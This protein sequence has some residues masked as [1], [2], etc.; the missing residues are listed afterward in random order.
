MKQGCAGARERKGHPGPT[1]CLGMAGAGVDCVQPLQ[2]L[3]RWCWALPGA[4]TGPAMPPVLCFSSENGPKQGWCGDNRGV[5]GVL[6]EGKATSSSALVPS[7][8]SVP[9]LPS[10]Q[11]GGECT[12]PRARLGLCF[13]NCIHASV[14]VQMRRA[15]HPSRAWKLPVI[16]RPLVLC[17]RAAMRV[18]PALGELTR[19]LFRAQPAC[20]PPPPRRMRT[21]CGPCSSST[22]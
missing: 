15:V 10:W 20:F 22:M 3:G 7:G 5:P 4:G 12:A 2:D 13:G 8:T 11:T 14:L 18:K 16:P 6:P 19:L 9:P 1:G 21:S 17:I